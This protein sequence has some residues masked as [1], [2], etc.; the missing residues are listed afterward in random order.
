MTTEAPL[1]I[2]GVTVQSIDVLNVLNENE[3]FRSA[4]RMKALE[5]MIGERDIR[6]ATLETPDGEAP[7]ST[8]EA[9]PEHTGSSKAPEAKSTKKAE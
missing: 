5:R 9:T 6:L 2:G 3:T 7:S 8:P 1:T 4:I